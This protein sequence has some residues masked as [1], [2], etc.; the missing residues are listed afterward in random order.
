M[1]LDMKKSSLMI[2]V[3]AVLLTFSFGNQNGSFSLTVPSTLA[4][5][6][7]KENSQNSNG[8]SSSNNNS[9]SNA[10]NKVTI[11]HYPPGNQSNLH[12]IDVGQPSVLNAHMNHGD[13]YGACL[14]CPSGA[15]ACVN[16]Y[17]LPGIVAETY[18][19]NSTI[20]SSLRELKGS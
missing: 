11:C 14:V 15:T 10:Q 13:T 18:G 6:C 2:G 4:G 19:A 9:S 17:G 16:A 20:P 12:T 5:S 7:S 3:F 1:T 8:N